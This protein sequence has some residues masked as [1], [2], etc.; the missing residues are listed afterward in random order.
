MLFCGVEFVGVF[1]DELKSILKLCYHNMKM[2]F[3]EKIGLEKP[4]TTLDKDKLTPELRSSIWNII[5]EFVLGSLGNRKDYQ[6]Y[7]RY[8]QLASFYRGI[9]INFFKRPVDELPFRDGEVYSEY[10]NRT[11]RDWFFA[12]GWNEVYEFMEYIV[13][14]HGEHLTSVFN[15][16]LKREFSAYRFVSKSLVEIN[17]A[18]EIVEI[19]NA[20]NASDKFSPVRIHLGSA[21]SLISDKQ[22]P[23]YRNSIKESISAVESLCKIIIQ[24]D[25]ATL[26]SALKT[27][28]QK[29]NIPESLKKGF[30]SIYGFTSEKGGIRHGLLSTDI[31]VG[32]DEA[33]FMLIACSAFINYLISKV[34]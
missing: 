28:E 34:D 12:A 31:I 27:I 2:R 16:I 17:S 1:E 33:R 20:L 8:S 15:E 9:W 22:N 26:G 7:E 18:E 3:S 32:V 11:L 5:L 29:H 19:E 6:G 30:S 23:D 4:R 24:D 21:L 13:E 10:P 14:H 25:A